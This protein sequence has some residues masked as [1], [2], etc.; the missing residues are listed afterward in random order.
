M[1]YEGRIAEKGQKQRDII[2]PVS[3]YREV[4]EKLEEL[5]YLRVGEYIMAININRISA[6][7]KQGRKTRVLEVTADSGTEGTIKGRREEISTVSLM[8]LLEA[9]REK[10][11]KTKVADPNFDRI[12]RP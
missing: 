10:Q 9:A 8:D 3:D 4:S 12:F 11:S 2:V 5:K 1:Q 7:K 6:D